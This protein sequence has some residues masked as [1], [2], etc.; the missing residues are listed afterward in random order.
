MH[1][2]RARAASGQGGEYVLRFCAAD[3][4]IVEFQ[5]LL[6]L[7]AFNLK[8]LR[9]AYPGDETSSWHV[10]DFAKP[11]L[12]REPHLYFDYQGIAGRIILKREDC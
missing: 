9:H 7:Q 4:P 6:A 2:D 1:V 3:H 5:M 12:E 10:T 8:A 11:W